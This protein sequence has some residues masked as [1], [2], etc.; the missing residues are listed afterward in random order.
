MIAAIFILM[1]LMWFGKGASNWAMFAQLLISLFIFD[2][3][4]TAIATSLYVMP[5]EMAVT[6]KTRGKII[7]VKVIFSII[8]LAVPLF[9]LPMLEDILKQSLVL[10]QLIMLGIGLVAGV[11]VFISSFFYK[12]NKYASKEEQYPFLKSLV[13][14]FKNRSFIIFEVISFSITYIQTALM[15]GLSYYFP[16]FSNVN[17]IICYGAMLIGLVLGMIV[18]VKYSP[19]M[20]IKNSISLMCLIFGIGMV[21]LLTLGQY[22]A[23]GIIGF[24]CA[25]LGFTGSMYLVPL[26]NGD[27]IDYDETKSG[28]RREGMYAGVN[29]FICKPA[30][31]IANAIIPVIM[32][33][34]GYNA[35]IDIVDQ[36]SRAKF[37]ILF[38]W[39]FIPAVLLFICAIVIY[40]FYP[41]HG[42][43]W[44][45]TKQELALR[46]QEK[47]AKF[48]QE[49]LENMQNESNQEN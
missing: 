8:S 31:S 15:F 33:W 9:L 14:C 12:E 24:F 34:F 3:L 4:Y 20:G 10:F 17:M 32:G 42:K 41:L 29:S 21:F 26:M 49:A 40:L 1:W 2:T 11:I 18:W 48:E 22:L 5:Y 36:T 28:L 19:K 27:V 45:E 43:K 16:A 46:H 44:L 47:Q 25:G 30:I 6:N 39:V 35:A 38:S 7:F 23:G 13:V 37:G